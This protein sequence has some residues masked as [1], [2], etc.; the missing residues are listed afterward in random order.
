MISFIPSPDLTVPKTPLHWRKTPLTRRGLTHLSL[1]ILR[2]LLLPSYLQTPHPPPP[3][4]KLHAT[5]YLDGL[6]GIAALI[7]VFDHFLV[8][9]FENLKSA[10]LAT[11]EDAYL[12]Q[13]PIIRLLYSGRASVA[14]F[15]VVSGFALSV[16]PIGMMREGRGKEGEVLKVLSSGVLRRGM[17]LYLPI[18]A[19]TF[20]S[21]V[22]AYCDVSRSFWSVL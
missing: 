20:I 15:F 8:N 14:V 1:R 11:P 2:H 13:L 10:Y 16:K 22:L 5:S 7:V 6:R 9:W 21:A 12:I 19:G 17:R 4:R 3:P 18:V